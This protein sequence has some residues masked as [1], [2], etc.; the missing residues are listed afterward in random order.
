MKTAVLQPL[1]RKTVKAGYK[2]TDFI[3]GLNVFLKRSS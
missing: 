2:I 1:G 3:T